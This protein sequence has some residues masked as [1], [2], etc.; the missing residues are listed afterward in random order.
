M[1][2]LLPFLSLVLFTT[3]CTPTIP[4]VPVFE[5]ERIFVESYL[6]PSEVASAYV[7]RTFAIG[8]I[9]KTVYLDN[10]T[11]ELWENGNKIDVLKHQK[12]GNYQSARGFR[13]KVGSAYSLKVQAG[14]LP[15]VESEAVVVPQPYPFKK[16]ETF[17]T[18][19][20]NEGVP[21]IGVTIFPKTNQ[22]G[23]YGYRIVPYFV[24]YPNLG[25]V[26]EVGKER[27]VTNDCQFRRTLYFARCGGSV[28]YGLHL[29][30]SVSS[31]TIKATLAYAELYV[32]SQ[33]YYDFQYNQKLQ[34]TYLQRAFFEPIESYTNM[35]G[36]YGV[37]GTFNKM[38][39]SIPL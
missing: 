16:L 17:Q 26:W 31:N 5:G 18:P 33:S 34:P 10:A 8:E 36:G 2:C 35:K 24:G 29:A 30:Q 14:S 11:V 27:E 28:S 38:Q 37:L 12:E 1:R 32:V 9:P 39:V 6:A 3:G 20:Q 7:G 19:G 21:A 22:P 15:P 13:P 4:Y 23:Y 25:F